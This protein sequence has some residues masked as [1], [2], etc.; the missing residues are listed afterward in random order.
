MLVNFQVIACGQDYLEGYS[1]KNKFLVAVQLADFV[2]IGEVVRTFRLPGT[3]PLYKNDNGYVFKVAEL[4][5]GESL[6]YM[7]SDNRL[8]A[9]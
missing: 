8:G 2:Y 5:K 1:E 4:M 9:E 7:E 6:A 3:P